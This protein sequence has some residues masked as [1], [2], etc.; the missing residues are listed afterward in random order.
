MWLILHFY[1]R[2]LLQIILAKSPRYSY[3]DTFCV[4]GAGKL[5]ST[6]QTWPTTCF[7]KKKYLLEYSHV[8]SFYIVH[9][10]YHG[11]MTEWSNYGRDCMTHK[12]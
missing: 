10:Y 4:A 2:A 3:T 5:W 7:Y 11:A 1:W 9:G 12:A 6:S 8:C